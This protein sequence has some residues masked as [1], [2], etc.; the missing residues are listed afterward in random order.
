[1]Y[2]TCNKILSTREL[3]EILHLGLCCTEHKQTMNVW[4][5]HDRNP[6]TLALPFQ[7]CTQHRFHF[8]MCVHDC[9]RRRN[10]S[11]APL[12]NYTKAI[13]SYNYLQW[14]KLN[15]KSAVECNFML[16]KASCWVYCTLCA[17]LQVQK[18]PSHLLRLVFSVYD[19]GLMHTNN[20]AYNNALRG[21]RRSSQ[22][23]SY[24]FNTIDKKKS[25]LHT[26]NASCAHGEQVFE[27]R[28]ALW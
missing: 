16:A 13:Y 21:C 7:T 8:H 1:M 27:I 10:L 9:R 17:T 24:R 6:I 23:E 28:N 19:L 5:F 20:Y 26:L 2:R 3:C 18:T 15:Y 11:V 12:V 4:S 22:Y 25:T 14:E